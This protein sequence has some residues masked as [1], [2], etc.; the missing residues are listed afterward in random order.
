[1]VSGVHYIPGHWRRRCCDLGT[2]MDIHER[3]RRNVRGFY[4]WIGSMVLLGVAP[5]VAFNLIEVG[6]FASRVTAVVIGVAG[7][8]P[9]IYVV[10]MMILRGDEYARRIHLVAL[11]VAF[12]GTM[13]LMIALDWLVKASFIESPDFMLV[14]LSAVVIWVIAVLVTKRQ[15]ERAR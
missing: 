12:L 9:W 14:W 2:H 11:A 1:M 4:I 13:L 7:T 5:I 6:T 10:A 15:Y 3:F 8:L